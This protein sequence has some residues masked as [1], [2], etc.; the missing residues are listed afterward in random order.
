M[1]MLYLGLGTNIGDK[2]ANLN[3]AICELSLIFG[4]Y[5]KCSQFYKSKPW[6][7]NSENEF[8]NAVVIFNVDIAPVEILS[9]TQQIE[10]NLGRKTKTVAGYTDR[11]I[12]IDILLIDN[13][14]VDEP[15]LQIPHPLITSRDFVLFPLA[16]VAGDIIHPVLKKSFNEL[17]A[18][19]E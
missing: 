4:A 17:K 6:G 9:K 10:K 15:L 3:K 8:L 19:K 2:E 5:L 16:E 12:D 11:I 13:Q 18:K 1:S 7:F 14:I